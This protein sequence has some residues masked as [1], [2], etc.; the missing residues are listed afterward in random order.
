M[1]FNRK[2]FK[3]IVQRF[4]LTKILIAGLLEVRYSEILKKITTLYSEAKCGNW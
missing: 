4:E 1:N 3:L 2:E